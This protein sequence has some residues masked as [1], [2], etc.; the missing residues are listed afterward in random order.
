MA[1]KKKIW[2]CPHCKQ[3]STRNWNLKT[4]I[5]RQHGGIGF[6][7]MDSDAI[8]SEVIYDYDQYD[9]RGYP[10]K[11]NL[12]AISSIGMHYNRRD[13]LHDMAYFIHKN[14]N[15][16][17][18]IIEFT[19][20]SKQLSSSS[21]ISHSMSVQEKP[22]PSHFI[23]DTVQDTTSISNTNPTKVLGFKI[24]YTCNRCLEGCVAPV[25]YPDGWAGNNQIKH[26]CK[27]E[28][29]LTIN[30]MLD[31]PK[32][33]F[34][35]LQIKNNSLQLL[36]YFVAASNYDCLV[37]IPLLNPVQEVLFLNNFEKPDIPIRIWYSKE[38][39]VELN[40]ETICQD[41]YDYTNSHWAARAIAQK[42]VRLT[43][44]EVSQFLETVG[45]ATYGFFKIRLKESVYD[46][47]LI[48]NNI[49]N[50]QRLL[51]YNN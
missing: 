34:E 32:R 35:Y 48:L 42:L 2:K 45:T 6:P 33:S 5:R 43:N 41:N 19:K 18:Q 11:T 49:L 20:L 31:N 4:H 36:K 51:L 7:I 38:S 26:S 24:F 8:T 40:I 30:N 12:D 47:F 50:A 46:S 44:N 17:S 3:T 28:R 22:N 14:N 15:L 23:S 27:P 9:Y 39:C 21:L 37:S 1:R 10:I 25:F 29:I 16:L 13:P